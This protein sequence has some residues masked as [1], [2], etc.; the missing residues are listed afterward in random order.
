MLLLG[1]CGTQEEISVV[2]ED[3]VEVEEAAAAVFPVEEHFERR[4]F[5]VFG[6]YVQDRFVGYHAADDI[7]VGGRRR[8]SSGGGD[9]GWY[10]DARRNGGRLWWAY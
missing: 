9:C 6:Q 2:L 8:G 4:T 1:A 7:E 5:K 10:G 3:D